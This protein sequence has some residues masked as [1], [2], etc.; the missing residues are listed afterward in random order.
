METEEG[1][2][3]QQPFPL[4]HC[5]VRGSRGSCYI[6]TCSICGWGGEKGKSATLHKL[7]YGHFLSLPKNDIKGCIS[8]ERIA[9]NYPEFYSKLQERLSS[10]NRKRQ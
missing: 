6:V 10:F 3:P 8:A 7:L 4:E 5:I 1:D 2:D 9:A